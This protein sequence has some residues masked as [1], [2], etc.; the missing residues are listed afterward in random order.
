[1]CSPSIVLSHFL[2]FGFRF[3]TSIFFKL[4]LVPVLRSNTSH[5][6]LYQRKMPVDPN[7][8]MEPLTAETIP[9]YVRL[10]TV[11]FAPTLNKIHFSP[12]GPLPSTTASIASR[13]YGFLEAKYPCFV[14]RD[15]TTGEI[16]SAAK[17]RLVGKIIVSGGD[18]EGEKT[19]SIR[20]LTEAELDE[21]LVVPPKW[22]ESRQDIWDAFYASLNATTREVMGTRPYWT[23]DALMTDPRHE[24]RG[25]ASMLVQWGCERADEMRIETFLTS[26]HTGTPVY[27]RCG[28]RTVKKVSFDPVKEVGRDVGYVFDYNAMIRPPRMR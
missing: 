2:P 10:R 25:A 1:M 8:I 28:F 27:E 26:S 20:G 14:V 13:V 6:K 3:L 19:A 12:G 4:Y 7:L 16:I 17:W 5:T 9:D 23:L 21:E 18:K 15:S 22:E 24:R 11:A